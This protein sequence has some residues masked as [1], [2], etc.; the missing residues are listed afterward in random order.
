MERFAKQEKLRIA[1]F[2]MM[3]KRTQEIRIRAIGDI[4]TKTVYAKRV[5]PEI[6]DGKKPETTSGF[7]RLS[8]TSASYPSQFW[9]QR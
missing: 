8:L 4:E 7:F 3:M 2:D 9:Y 1:A 5:D 6:D